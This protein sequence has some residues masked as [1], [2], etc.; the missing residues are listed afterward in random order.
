[1]TLQ[2]LLSPAEGPDSHLGPCSAVRARGASLRELV[3]APALSPGEA[4]YTLSTSFHNMYIINGIILIIPS[5]KKHLEAVTVCGL[6]APST[7]EPP[8]QLHSPDHFI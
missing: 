7:G 8:S 2:R 3:H 5:N 4:H 6:W 1:M